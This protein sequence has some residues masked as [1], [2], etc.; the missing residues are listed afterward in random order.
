M[1]LWI[2]LVVRIWMVSIFGGGAYAT[3]LD[4]DHILQ[5]AQQGNDRRQLIEQDYEIANRDTEIIASE[6]FPMINFNLQSGMGEKYRDNADGSIKR[7]AHTDHSFGVTLKTPLYAFGRIGAVFEMADTRKQINYVARSQQIQEYLML[8]IQ[9][10]SRALLNLNYE[11]VA[12]EQV[13]HTKSLLDF[14]RIEFENG[15]RSK[16]DFLRT[17]STHSRARA[18]LQRSTTDAQASLVRLKNILGL[19]PHEPLKLKLGE[20]RQVRFLNVEKA[21]SSLDQT[22]LMQLSKLNLNLYDQL[23]DYRRALHLPTLYLTAQVGSQATDYDL[24]GGP[25]RGFSDLGRSDR[26]SYTVALSLEWNLFSGLRTSA[27]AGKARAEALKAGVTYRELQKEE[28][29]QRME[30]ASKLESAKII[31]NA[32]IEA[33][34]AMKL[35]FDQSE[36][37]YQAGTVSLTQMLEVQTDFRDAQKSVFEA[38]VNQITACTE[39]RVAHRL[40]LWEG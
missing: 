2:R 7:W 1:R 31:L 3:D 29:I 24:M 38:Y 22:Y 15:A 17:K 30:S 18:N 9:H 21:A 8:V 23:T 27:E 28:E 35:A 12:R 32:S 20:P 6:A 19:R 5:L 25:E 16:I 36:A 13:K 34:N 4:L 39:Y 26:L 10:Y 11:N 14:T 37:D 33:R 40:S